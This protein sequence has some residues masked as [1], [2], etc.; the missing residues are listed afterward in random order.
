V[1]ALGGMALYESDAFK[2]NSM[3]IFF[4][5]PLEVEYKQF[6]GVFENNLSI[7]DLLMFNSP[8]EITNHLS[9]FE[10]LK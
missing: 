1:N 5:K 3:K 4:L 6:S 9:I 7:I 2:N 10:L 8:G